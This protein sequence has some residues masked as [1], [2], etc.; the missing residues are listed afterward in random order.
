M[1]EQVGPALPPA[2]RARLP[3]DMQ[4]QPM[5]PGATNHLWRLEADG[6]RWVWR[7]FVPAPGVDRAR[8]Q[9][10]MRALQGF[11]W[12]PDLL[13]WTPQGML[14]PWIDGA[15]APN[16][17]PDPDQRAELLTL[18]NELWARPL[19]EVAAWDY[20]QLVC[21]YEAACPDDARWHQ[22]ADR[23]ISACRQ[24]PAATPCLMHHDLHPGNLLLS[25]RQWTLL[26]WEFAA[27]GNPWIDAVCVDRWLGLSG[28]ERAVLMPVLAPHAVTADPWAHYRDWVEGLE[29][30]WYAAVA[31]ET[32]QGIRTP[33]AA[34]KS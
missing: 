24:W 22:L 8:E 30:L 34:T 11:A 7:Q 18:L 13:A 23:L 9:T 3:E 10:I 4:A 27:R 33:R 19:P 2:V 28:P 15:P 31:R 6:Q 5:A 20:E 25:G 32:A 21:D 26:D 17:K 1:T 14:L 29:K 16:T 12:M